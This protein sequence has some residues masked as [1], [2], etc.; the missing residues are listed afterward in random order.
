MT[1]KT[2]DAERREKARLRSERWRRA[3]GIMPRRKA[4]RPW[5]AEGH[6]RART[7][8]RRRA[9]AP[10]ASGEHWLLRRRRGRRCSTASTGNL[11][12]CGAIL[13]RCCAV[14]GSRVRRSSPSWPR[15]QA[16]RGAGSESARMSGLD[17]KLDRLGARGLPSQIQLIYGRCPRQLH[18][19]PACG[20]QGLKWARP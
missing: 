5:L 11:H 18:Q 6:L 1:T 16:V 17:I 8:Y 4:A 19:H 20:G 13:K 3:H 2:H 10:R 9:K 15:W 7:W 14:C 12:N